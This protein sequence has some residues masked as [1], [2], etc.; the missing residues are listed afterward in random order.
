MSMV[1]LLVVAVAIGY[2]AGR[3]WVV[4]V[5]VVLGSAAAGLFLTSGVSLHDTPLLFAVGLASVGLV[6]GLFAR[7]WRRDYGNVR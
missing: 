6:G 3:W 7:R 4:A 2:Q 5:P 1:F